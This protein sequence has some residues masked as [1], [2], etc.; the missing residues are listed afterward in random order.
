MKV[1]TLVDGTTINVADE[2][3]VGN[4]RIPVQDFAD[5]DG[6]KAHFTRENMTTI[7]IGAE[8]FHQVNPLGFY[9]SDDDGGMFMTVRCQESLQD[10][11][12]NQID[13]VILQL[14]EEGVIE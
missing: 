9:V 5:A 3:G 10:Y 2:S 12:N 14:I 7:T 1:L 6:I 4:I 13:N 11:V 8:E